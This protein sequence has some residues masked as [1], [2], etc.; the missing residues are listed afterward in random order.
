MKARPA[1]AQYRR[2]LPHLQNYTATVF[3]TFSTWKR[4]ELPE[5]VRSAIVSHCLH[6]NKTKLWMHGLVVMPDHVHLIFSPLCDADGDAFGLAEIMGGIKGASAHAVNRT[7]GRSGHVWQD[8]SFDHVLR[9][10]E[11]IREKVEYICSNPVRR[12]L[13]KSVDE[14]PWLWREWVEGISSTAADVA[15]PP[16][17]VKKKQDTAEGRCATCRE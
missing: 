12:G 4:W 13:A 17:A 1:K 5:C 8:E 7:L 15:Q 16:P 9:S 2:N 3:V 14:Y 6:D 10:G 11:K